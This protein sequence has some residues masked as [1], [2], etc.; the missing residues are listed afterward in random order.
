MKPSGNPSHPITPPAGE[1]PPSDPRQA[2]RRPSSLNSSNNDKYQKL[3][4]A[5]PSRTSGGAAAGSLPSGGTASGSSAAPWEISGSE[6]AGG[7]TNIFMRSQPSSLPISI[8]FGGGVLSFAGTTS[9]SFTQVDEC[10]K[11]GRRLGHLPDEC[12]LEGRCSNCGS[13]HHAAA[14]CGNPTIY[15]EFQLPD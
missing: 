10:W 8:N 1:P 14:R 11:C 9:V 15:F 6:T 13:P 3:N 5:N 2:A 7:A 4:N 12:W